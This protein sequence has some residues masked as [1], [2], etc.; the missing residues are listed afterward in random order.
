[1]VL[2]LLK[3]LWRPFKECFFGRLILTRIKNQG[4]YGIFFQKLWI[5]C[6]CLCKTIVVF[7]L[8]FVFF[9]IFCFFM[10]YTLFNLTPP[11]PIALIFVRSNGMFGTKFGFCFA[12][13]TFKWEHFNWYFF[14]NWGKENPFKSIA[15]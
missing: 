3:K 5:D 15:N 4:G 2:H 13:L 8:I 12:E 9:S 11:H 10:F 1:M 14:A 7:L 6:P